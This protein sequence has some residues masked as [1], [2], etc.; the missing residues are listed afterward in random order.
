MDGHGRE[1]ST[2]SYSNVV[3][4]G[5]KEMNLSNFLKPT[6]AETKTISTQKPESSKSLEK[7]GTHKEVRRETKSRDNI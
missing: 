3:S 1:S 4:N 5:S 7:E 6:E 2:P